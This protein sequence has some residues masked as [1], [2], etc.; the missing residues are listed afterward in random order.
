MPFWTFSCSDLRFR[1]DSVTV[2]TS[3]R[4]FVAR[5]WV[6]QRELVASTEAPPGLVDRTGGAMHLG[7]GTGEAR[8]APPDLEL[9]DLL[10][11]QRPVPARGE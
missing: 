7:A 4:D 10:D 1:H 5:F 11:V 6:H 3:V 9:V 2:P 8:D